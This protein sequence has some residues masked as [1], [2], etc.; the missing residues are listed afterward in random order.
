M[1][2]HSSIALLIDQLKV[3]YGNMSEHW[4]L[5][6]MEIVTIGHLRLDKKHHLQACSARLI[7][8]HV[9]QRRCTLE[10][11]TGK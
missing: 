1:V 10:F 3:Q 5:K 6:N 2:S 7:P 8:G 9:T 11:R 4:H